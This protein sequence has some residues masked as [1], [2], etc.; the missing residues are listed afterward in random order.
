[1]I[2]C[3]DG[4]KLL[5]GLRREYNFEDTQVI[6][7]PTIDALKTLFDV[8]TSPHELALL[9][10]KILEFAKTEN[11]IEEDENDSILDP[12]NL[13]GLLINVDNLVVCAMEFY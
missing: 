4:F 11:Q 12:E 3:S 9:I 8:V 6:V 10:D 13:T 5:A 2:T 7:G 1:M